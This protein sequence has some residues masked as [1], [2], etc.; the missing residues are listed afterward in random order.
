MF[1]YIS[2]SNSSKIQLLNFFGQP[3]HFGNTYRRPFRLLSL[4]FS[5]PGISCLHPSLLF[6]V[7][8]RK[9]YLEPD[10]LHSQQF[11]IQRFLVSVY[12][13]LLRKFIPSTS[14]DN[15][16]QILSLNGIIV[17]NHHVYIGTFSMVCAVTYNIY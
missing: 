9:M 3:N 16:D 12:D 1:T 8:V 13:S 5:P 2:A 4:I 17:P 11:Y 14:L 15:P 6:L 10:H 7:L